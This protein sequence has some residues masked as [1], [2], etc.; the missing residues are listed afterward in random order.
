[1]YA[2][3]A[4]LSCSDRRSFQDGIFGFPSWMV[5]SK[6]ASDFFRIDGDLRLA[7]SAPRSL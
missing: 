2:R 7:G 4:R 6:A 1:M 3:T 5:F